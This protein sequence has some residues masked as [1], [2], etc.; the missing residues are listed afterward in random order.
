MIGDTLK[1]ARV[2]INISQ[3]E[4]ANKIN[5][6]KQTYMKWENDITE[7]KASQVKKL[8]EILYLSETEICRG[9][10]G[11]RM[12]LPIFIQRLSQERPSSELQLLRLWEYID[13]HEE[14]FEGLKPKTEEEYNEMEGGQNEIYR[15]LKRH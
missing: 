10:V 7:P 4:M 14:F 9:K 3:Q 2:K 6:T 8:A 1:E 5:V 12:S 11:K 15:E 13:D